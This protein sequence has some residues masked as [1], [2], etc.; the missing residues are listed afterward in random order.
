M[1]SAGSIARMDGASRNNVS[2]VGMEKVL[3]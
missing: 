3:K 1:E 2:I